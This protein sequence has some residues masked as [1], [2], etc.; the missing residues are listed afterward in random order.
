[1]DPGIQPG[2]GPAA[3]SHERSGARAP[4]APGP[5]S[6]GEFPQEGRPAIS[7]GVLHELGEDDAHFAAALQC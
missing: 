6:N 4:S 5:A 3:G 1:M 2:E 7:P